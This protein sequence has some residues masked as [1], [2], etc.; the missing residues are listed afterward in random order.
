MTLLFLPFPLLLLLLTMSTAMADED[1]GEIRGL[2]LNMQAAV[3]TT[4]GFNGF[5]CGS[6]GDSPGTPLNGWT[7]FH[8]C[9]PEPNGLHEVHFRFD[10]REGNQAKAYWHPAFPHETGDTRVAGHPVILS[11]LFNDAGF[12]EGIRIV[13]D[14]RA[15]LPQ[16]RVAQLLR[17]SVIEH[18]GEQGW[19]CM[20]LP[21]GS[22]ETPVGKIFI[23]Q[24]CEKTTPE[25][26]L[27]MQARLLRKPGQTAYDPATE[28]YKPGQFESSTRLE[29]WD[30]SLKV[31]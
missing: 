21:P 5:A 25:H 8:L 14:P 12:I 29:I 20:D 1:H 17:L 19:T 11:V 15:P 18:Y 30:P 4:E 7:D 3:M 16:R 31:E 10:D 24:R 13:T 28:Q 6:N 22:G 9:K 26:H 27:V 23:K 2:K